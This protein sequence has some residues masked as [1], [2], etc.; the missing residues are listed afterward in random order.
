[1]FEYLHDLWFSKV[2]ARS[3]AIMLMTFAFAYY[4]TPANRPWQEKLI[5]A[6]GVSLPV[7]GAALSMRRK[8]YELNDSKEEVIIAKKGDGHRGSNC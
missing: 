2:A 5:G 1:M 8:P 4:N 6:I 7:T 3:F